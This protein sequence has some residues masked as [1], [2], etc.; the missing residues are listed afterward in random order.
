[1]TRL[2]KQTRSS[3]GDS[4]VVIDFDSWERETDAAELYV[5]GGKEKWIPKSVLGEVDFE[6]NTIEVREWFAKKEGLI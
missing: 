3:G 5:I 1:M 4:Y 6:E 2:S